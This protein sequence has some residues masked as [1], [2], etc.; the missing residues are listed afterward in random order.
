MT[1]L[2][3]TLPTRSLGLRSLNPRTLWAR[4]RNAR[5]ITRQR[6]ALAALDDAMLRDIGL[7]RSD[8]LREAGRPFWDAPRHWRG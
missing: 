7:T 6:H 1:T 4:L 5:A 3:T 8:A 2:T